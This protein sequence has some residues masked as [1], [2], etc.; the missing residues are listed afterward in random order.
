MARRN[1][2]RSCT[3]ARAVPSPAMTLGERLRAAIDRNNKSH[4]WVAQEAGITPA[5][6]SAILTGKTGD[7]SFFTVLAIA[8]T[9]GEPLSA[10]MDDPL[11]YWTS[12]ELLESANPAFP[13]MPVDEDAV[14]FELIGIVVTKERK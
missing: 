11:H 5:S 6:L 2:T 7:P 12:E 4:A 8:R 13:P 10:I 3:L 1:A 9:L 14:R